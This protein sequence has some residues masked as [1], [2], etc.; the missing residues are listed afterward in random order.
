MDLRK[1]YDDVMELQHELRIKVGIQALADYTKRTPY[2][3][4][5]NYRQIK[6]LAACYELQDYLSH[7]IEVAIEDGE[8][9]PDLD[10]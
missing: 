6:A 5:L 8:L 4:G 7:R 2:G 3:P 1:M 9:E 10:G